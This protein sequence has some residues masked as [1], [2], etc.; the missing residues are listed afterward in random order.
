VDEALR[1]AEIV[2][3]AEAVD[4]SLAGQPIIAEA[5]AAVPEPEPEEDA[6]IPELEGHD[7]N[8]GRHGR[9]DR[10]GRDRRDRGTPPPGPRHAPVAAPP[11]P[12]IRTD[13]RSLAAAARSLV[14]PEL[15][16]AFCGTGTFGGPWGRSE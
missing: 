9:Y 5:G 15:R 14:T 8:R 2:S 6:P 16:P 1:L 7:P 10:G 3:D 4:T 11:L 12:P 13:L